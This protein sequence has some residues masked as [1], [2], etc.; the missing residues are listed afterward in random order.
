MNRTIIVRRDSKDLTARVIEALDAEDG[1]I[2]ARDEAILAAERAEATVPFLDRAE[3]ES[4]HIQ[5]YVQFVNVGGQFY[6]RDPVGTDLT[7]ADSATWTRIVNP[8]AAEN[9]AIRDKREFR[10][11][12]A[13]LANAALTYGPGAAHVQAGDIVRTRAEG[14]AYRVVASD[15]ADYDLATAGGVRL[16]LQPSDAGHYNFAGMAPAADGVTDDYQK[17]R[18]LL[19]RPGIQVSTYYSIPPIYIPNGRYYIGQTIQLK[20]QVHIFGEGSGINSDQT[21]FL[22]FP[23]DTT[24]II[25]HRQDTI[26]DTTEAATTGADGTIID[27]IRLL[28]T[29]GTD[30]AK[31]GI[32]LRA[33]AVLRNFDASGFSGNG[34]NIVAT[35][36]G[37]PADQGNA[38]NFYIQSARVT[39]NGGSGVYIRGADVNAGILIGV[40]ASHN[41]RSGIED[42]AFL[43]NTHIGHHVS[44]N[45]LANKGFNAAD[46]SSFVSYDGRRYAAHWSTTEALLVATTPGTDSTVWVDQGAGGASTSVPLWTAGKP[47]GTYFQAYGYWLTSLNARGVL[48][49]CYWESGAPG[50]VF[51]GP[52]M[53]FGGSL[54]IVLSGSYFT[55]DTSGGMQI[56]YLLGTGGSSGKGRAWIGSGSSSPNAAFGWSHPDETGTGWEMVLVN[57]DWRARNGR[58]ASRD[59]FAITGANTTQTFGSAAPTPYTLWAVGRLGLGAGSAARRVSYGA[60]A[61]EVARGDIFFETA[62]SAAGKAG[63]ICTTAGIIGSTAVM[64]P[65]GAIDA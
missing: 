31:H 41:G 11:L 1:L 65:F 24:G 8:D 45:G 23:P 46:Q 56:P 48:L 13:L 33:R 25:V 40:D 60:P 34:I 39:G 55:R 42:R 30:K 2:A 20:R 18:R 28:S 36:G 32:W 43:G 6:E 4:T 63:Q 3:A 29:P 59:A 49:G 7:T 62:A 16:Y 15:D 27:G 10:D 9:A 44:Y 5:P 54:G 22:V 53:A 26:D 38:N 17:L 61:G 12:P 58:N 51:L 19:D 21:A 14:F 52:N 47:V 64:K 50:S 35:S 57:G 37:A